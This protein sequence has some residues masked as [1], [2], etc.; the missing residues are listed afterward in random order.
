MRA[1]NSRLPAARTLSPACGLSGSRQRW[2]CFDVRGVEPHHAV[3]AR[4]F[5]NNHV[6]EPFGSRGAM[7]MF[8]GVRDRHRI[9]GSQ[10]TCRTTATCHHLQNLPRGMRVPVVAAAGFEDH[11]PHRIVHSLA[12]RHPQVHVTLARKVGLGFGSPRENAFPPDRS[13]FQGIEKYV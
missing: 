10:R 13:F 1:T 2:V 3:V 7:S 9:A 5:R 11:V 12:A 4:I 8:R 6:F